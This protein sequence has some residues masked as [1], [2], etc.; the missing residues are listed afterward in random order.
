MNWAIFLDFSEPSGHKTFCL[1]TM[2]G[3][4]AIMW[5]VRSCGLDV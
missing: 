3:S 1:N 2:L 5:I 4:S